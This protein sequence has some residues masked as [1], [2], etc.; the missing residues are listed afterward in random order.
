MAA[1]RMENKRNQLERFLKK[2]NELWMHPHS[3]CVLGPGGGCL[4]HR[5]G[6][7]WVSLTPKSVRGNGTEPSRVTSDWSSEISTLV[8]KAQL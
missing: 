1:A 4:N 7:M 6:L 5:P 8:L 3:E 2:S